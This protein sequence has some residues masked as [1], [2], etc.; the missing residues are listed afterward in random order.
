MDISVVAPCLN[1]QANLPALLARTDA[2]LDAL[3]LRAEI[4]LVDDGS[5]DATFATMERLACRYPR[6]IPLRHARNRGIPAAWRTGVAAARGALVCILDADLQNRPEDIPRLLAALR[7]DGATLAQGWRATRGRARGARYWLSRGMNA[8]LN[9]AFGMDLP[10]N[11]SGFLLCERAALAELLV[12]RGRYHAWQNLIMVAAHAR[13]LRS[14]GVVTAFD[15]RHAGRSFLADVPLRH[16]A[17]SLLDIPRA[18]RE[19]G[20]PARPR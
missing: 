20:R 18:L 10:D 16:G 19:Y 17:L 4:I 1:E 2:V 15:P 11:K 7:R 8:L 3:A 5:T 6:L 13:G 9:A 14:T 12:C